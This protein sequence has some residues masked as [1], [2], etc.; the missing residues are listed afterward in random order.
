M[1]FLQ[2]EQGYTNKLFLGGKKRKGSSPE[3][4]LLEHSRALTLLLHKHTMSRRTVEEKDGRRVSS[5][6]LGK[7]KSTGPWPG[8]LLVPMDGH[9]VQ[10]AGVNE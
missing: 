7:R 2:R 6:A 1:L 8:R 3:T 5:T 10:Q 4:T 9:V